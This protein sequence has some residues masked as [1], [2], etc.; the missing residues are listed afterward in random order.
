MIRLIGINIPQVFALSPEHSPSL[1]TEAL[2]QLRYVWDFMFYL[3]GVVFLYADLFDSLDQDTIKKFQDR[4]LS[5]NDEEWHRLVDPEARAALLAKKRSVRVYCSKSSNPRRITCQTWWYYK[6]SVLVPRVNVGHLTPFASL[7]GLHAAV[8]T[9][10]PTNYTHRPDSKL[11]N[12]SLL[13][14]R[15][16]FGASP[17]LVAALFE[18]QRDQHPVI[19]SVSD[20]ILEAVL[21]FRDD[22][23]SY[24][25]VRLRLLDLLTA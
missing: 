20:I 1:R 23:D 3:I 15:L 12:G 14:L 10:E 5:D 25:K 16:H 22:Y 6:K 4:L 18:R 11:Y 17:A 2:Q 19:S 7:L 24:I 13:E 21:A 8:D 9:G